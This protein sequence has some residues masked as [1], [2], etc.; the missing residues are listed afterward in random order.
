MGV[1]VVVVGVIIGVVVVIVVVVGVKVALSLVGLV[2]VAL[3]VEN[4]I[5]PQGEIVLSAESSIKHNRHVY[6]E[7]I[8]KLSRR[9]LIVTHK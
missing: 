7:S 4:F 9:S 8:D 2:L 5:Y 3:A 1:G 6:C